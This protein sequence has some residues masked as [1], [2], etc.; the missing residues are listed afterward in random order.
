[1]LL[2]RLWLSICAAL[3]AAGWVLGAAHC[4]TPAGYGV[5]LVAIAV[6]VGLRLRAGGRI[7]RW[8][9]LGFRGLRGLRAGFLV[10]SALTLLGGLLHPL[11]TWDT[12]AYRLPRV[13][14][15]L[16]VG[17]WHWIQAP[18]EWMNNRA[19]GYEFLMAPGVALHAWRFLWV[20]NFVSFIL[21][22]GLVFVVLRQLR[23]P[24]ARPTA[25]PG[26]CR[27]RIFFSCKRPAPRMT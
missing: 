16:A 17:H 4:F 18:R 12:L 19:P 11:S 21:L 6:G 9:P 25:G 3:I 23:T 15:W 26:C 7:P 10:L 5:V 24:C 14:H 13:C 22:P 2:L 27:Q 8:R 20:P 1:V